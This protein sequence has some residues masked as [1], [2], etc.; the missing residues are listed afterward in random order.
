M[1]N[2]RNGLRPVTA[3]QYSKELK[4]YLIC[5]NQEGNLED[6]IGLYAAI[7]LEDGKVTQVD[8]YNVKFDDV[9]EQK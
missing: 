4:G 5:F 3:K 9:E 7:E 8:A 2:P 6:G 1:R